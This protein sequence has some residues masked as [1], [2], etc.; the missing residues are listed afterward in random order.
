MQRPKADILD[1]TTSKRLYSEF[2]KNF[3]SANFFNIQLLSAVYIIWYLIQMTV[4][5]IVKNIPTLNVVLIWIYIIVV[6]IGFTLFLWIA[7]KKCFLRR[8]LDWSIVA[9]I[10]GAFLLSLILYI[11]NCPDL[12]AQEKFTMSVKN[13]IRHSFAV[14][15]LIPLI[16]ALWIKVLLFSSILAG[17]LIE[18][19]IA[20][21]WETADLVDVAFFS[22]PTCLCLTF[23]EY[24][25]QNNEKRVIKDLANLFDRN[26]TWRKIIDFIPYGVAVID[27]QENVLFQNPG[28]K[29]FFSQVSLEE[30]FLISSLEAFKC[31]KIR[32]STKNRENS[33]I[34]FHRSRTLNEFP[35]ADSIDQALLEF[36]DVTL[37]EAVRK[38][39]RKANEFIEKG[40]CWD[41]EKQEPLFLYGDAKIHDTS[42]EIAF[43][44]TIFHEKISLLLLI[45]DTSIRDAIA[46]IEDR[47]EYKS[48]LLSSVSHELRTPV[49]GTSLLLQEMLQEPQIPSS[50]KEKY[51]KPVLL[52][53]RRLVYMVQGISDYSELSFGRL[54]RLE[55]VRF[56]VKDFLD[57]LFEIVKF[58]ANKK[59]LSL[60]FDL[61]KDIPE[62]IYADRERLGELLMNLLSNAMKF[63]QRGGVLLRIGLCHQQPS[64]D[65]CID[66]RES[67]LL[68]SIED[69]G[70][71]MAEDELARLQLLLSQDLFDGKIS[72]GSTGACL[73][74]KISN[75]IAKSMDA[76]LNISSMVDS[77][78]TVSFVLPCKSDFFTQL[79]PRE[80]STS[81]WASDFLKEAV[82]G[83]KG[84]IDERA[85]VNSPKADYFDIESIK[86]SFRLNCSPD[87]SPHNQSIASGR[88]AFQ[89]DFSSRKLMN[90]SV[91]LGL[92]EFESLIEERKGKGLEYVKNQETPQGKAAILKKSSLYQPRREVSDLKASSLEHS[93]TGL[94]LSELSQLRNGCPKVLIVDDDPFNVDSVQRILEKK[95]VRTD[96]AF[97][98]K[99]AVEKLDQLFES[100]SLHCDLVQCKGIKLILMD[101]NMP[102]MNGCE[103]TELIKQKCSEGRMFDC[104]VVGCTAYSGQVEKI[105]C[106]EAGMDHLLIKPIRIEPILSFL[107]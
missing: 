44:Y 62:E 9:G 37:D 34:T 56:K 63:T 4:V 14:I 30:R 94:R 24:M 25:T 48:F 88:S 81:L 72:T 21:L 35:R 104:Q 61:E 32:R 85:Q 36:K 78:T 71:G 83:W 86:P 53:I 7:R 90:C 10:G 91:D 100:H 68:F 89:K 67:N 49:N 42:V 87:N 69:T 43:G 3:I 51:L 107:N 52:N 105:K 82:P 18:I 103:A 41:S 15:S 11:F 27:T 1:G 70:I 66:V 2:K 19:A 23:F 28:F 93:S 22:L 5:S 95:G 79:G 13:L 39:L 106:Y 54:L 99:E 64:N 102:I 29:G 20:R 45:Q 17:S 47:D 6:G 8:L 33:A 73:G 84:S 55:K 16:E 38:F 60:A 80:S 65:S 26:V 40:I 76:E 96:C 31:F 74:L 97:N 57:E 59:R 92:G 75:V 98:G 12:T 50:I 46:K 58:E 77:G 101:Y